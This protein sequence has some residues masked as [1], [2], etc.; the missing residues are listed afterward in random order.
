MP[1]CYSNL[2]SLIF[3]SAQCQA[4][5]YSD[6]GFEMCT[7]CPTGYYQANPQATTCEECAKTETNTDQTVAASCAPAG[8]MCCYNVEVTSIQGPILLTWFNFNPGMNK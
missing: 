3:F 6:T 7:P 4:G 8:K 2:T 1:R 5:S